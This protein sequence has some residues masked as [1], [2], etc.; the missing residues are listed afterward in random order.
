MKQI[1]EKETPYMKGGETLKCKNAKILL[2]EVQID[3]LPV[4][5]ND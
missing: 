4:E 3:S 2:L 1:L 5:M